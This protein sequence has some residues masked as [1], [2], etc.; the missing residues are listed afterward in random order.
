MAFVDLPYR[1][2]LL[3]L[4]A[5]WAAV[6]SAG[7]VVVFDAQSYVGTCTEA[8]LPADSAGSSGF[9]L[10]AVAGIAGALIFIAVIV[11]VVLR[12]RRS[13]GPHAAKSLARKA[14]AEHDAAGFLYANPL[15]KASA[16]RL[17]PAY[18]HGN[19]TRTE[20]ERRVHAAGGGD[21]AF[22]LAMDHGACDRFI[23]VVSREGRCD[24]HSIHHARHAL[25]LDGRAC[26]ED[27]RSVDALVAPPAAG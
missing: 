12:R 17:T 23:L 8:V 11:V 16:P 2:N 20:A 15:F 4:T 10:A 27:L 6:C 5:Q 22:L 13:R 14:Q 9:P 26:G 3:Q 25:L 24:H 19:I 18:Y 1:A 21:G 7:V